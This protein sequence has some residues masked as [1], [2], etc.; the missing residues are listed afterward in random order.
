MK[1]LLLII[2]CISFSFGVQAQIAE[3]GDFMID[4]G[5]GFGAGTWETNAPTDST[6]A[7]VPGF[8]NVEVRYMLNEKFSGYLTFE[9]NKFV[10]AEEDSA[11][12][13]SRNFTLGASYHFLN[14]DKHTMYLS[15]SAGISMLKAKST[16]EIGQE[17]NFFYDSTGNVLR[18]EIG[19]NVYFGNRVGFFYGAGYSIYN[20]NELNYNFDDW[21]PPTGILSHDNGTPAD[22]SDD[23]N[24]TINAKNVDIR[25]GI[26]VK[27]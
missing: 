9:R 1:N 21:D 2:T 24:L 22:T 13:R 26:T 23:Q 5:F 16:T 18:F 19:G 3:K 27:I 10:N 4:L 17:L 15:G 20:Y 12:V 14:R 25:F 7:A 8:V 11:D 6:E